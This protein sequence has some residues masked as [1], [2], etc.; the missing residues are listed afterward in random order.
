MK[1]TRL[2]FLLPVALLM[3]A[4]PQQDLPIGV[5]EAVDYV[6]NASNKGTDDF[7]INSAT[8]LDDELTVS[9]SYG[10][11]C[12]PE[13]DFDAELTLLPTMGPLPV[14]Q[15]YIHLKDKDNCEALLTEDICFDLSAAGK[16]V[17]TKGFLEIVGP[18][19][20]LDIDWE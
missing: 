5:C 9:V 16:A 14:Y 8:V 6:N 1:T 7:T 12:G 10:G 20:T 15:L 17:G 19:D 3:T 2:L 18:D 13:V 4:C 11:G